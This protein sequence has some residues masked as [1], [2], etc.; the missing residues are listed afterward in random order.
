MA[1]KNFVK[2]AFF[3]N[4]AALIFS[5]AIFKS[6]LFSIAK[7]LQ[8]SSDRSNW[9]SVSREKARQINANSRLN[10]FISLIHLRQDIGHMDNI[11]PYLNQK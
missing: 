9:A 1:G 6:L 4:F 7:A 8:L 5:S 2:A 11:L 3:S 10:L